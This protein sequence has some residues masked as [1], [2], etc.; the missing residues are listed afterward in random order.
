MFFD[1][2]LL[3]ACQIESVRMAVLLEKGLYKEA[4]AEYQ[5]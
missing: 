4:I 2:P 5:V 3:F 1:K